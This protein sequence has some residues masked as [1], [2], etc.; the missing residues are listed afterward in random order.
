MAAGQVIYSPQ[1]IILPAGEPGQGKPLPDA[2]PSGTVYGRGIIDP[3]MAYSPSSAKAGVQVH[4]SGTLMKTTDQVPSTLEVNN[5]AAA[6]HVVGGT[7]MALV[8]TTGAG[9]T[10]LSTPFFCHGSGNTIPAGALA[11]DGLPTYVEFGNGFVTSSYDPGGGIQRAVSITIAGSASANTVTV[12]GWDYYGY[13]MSQAVTTAASETVATLK[14]FKFVKS[15]T[16]LTTDAHNYSVGTADVFGLGLVGNH[17][18]DTLCYFGDILQ[19]ASGIFV[20]PDATNPATTLTGDVRGTFGP[21]G[22]ATNGTLR[23]QM[24]NILTGGMVSS[25]QGLT[26]GMYGQT[27]V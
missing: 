8:S 9:I 19:V 5:I 18:C 11:I 20:V 17:F 3:R 7:P 16:A 6:A 24:F 25:S 26:I 23:L 2:A 1:H 14:T 22:S 4:F 13:P 12:V 21:F 15:V 10:V 27:Q